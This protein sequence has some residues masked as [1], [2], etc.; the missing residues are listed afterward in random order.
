MHEGSRCH[1]ESGFVPAETLRPQTP[2][3]YGAAPLVTA[4][5]VPRVGS[6]RACKVTQ[7]GNLNPAFRSVTPGGVSGPL[8]SPV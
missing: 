3:S 2:E 7:S 4:G 8:G 5:N 6:R 1:T